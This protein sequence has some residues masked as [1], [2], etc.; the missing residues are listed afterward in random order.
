[1][2]AAEKGHEEWRLPCSIRS[3]KAIDNMSKQIH[4]V[5][6]EMSAR[7]QEESSIDLH[8]LSP[9][10]RLIRARLCQRRLI[11]RRRLR[12]RH[13]PQRHRRIRA[14]PDL[15]PNLKCQK[16]ARLRRLSLSFSSLCSCDAS[17]SHS[18][19][20][21]DSLGLGFEGIEGLRGGGGGGEDW[22][23]RRRE[24]E[25]AVFVGLGEGDVWVGVRDSGP[26]EGFGEM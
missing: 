9:P 14:R 17:D 12:L 4:G 2:T 24:F 15:Q 5:Y 18:I 22:G 16:L 10:E 21:G 19:A 25:D 8:R 1:M 7:G 20:S 6:I 3:C 26:G 23:W 13:L 11:T